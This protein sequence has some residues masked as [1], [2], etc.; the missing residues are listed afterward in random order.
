MRRL[1]TTILLG[2]IAFATLET[3]EEVQRCINFLTSSADY[4]HGKGNVLVVHGM[5]IYDVSTWQIAL[6]LA[7][8]DGFTSHNGEILSDLIE[9]QNYSLFSEEEDW[10]T[11]A[12]FF[13]GWEKI[14]DMVRLIGRGHEQS[15]S[16]WDLANDT[17][18]QVSWADW[19]PITVENAWV[20]LI[21]PLQSDCIRFRDLGYVPLDRLSMQNAAHVLKL[22]KALQSPIGGVYYTTTGS[23]GNIDPYEISVES[24]ASLYAGLTIFHQLLTL[25]PDDTEELKIEVEEIRN[26]IVHFFKNYAW[27]P[28][29]GV[30]LQG[31]YAYE[32][33]WQPIYFPKAVDVQTSTIM[34]IGP[35]T[36]DEWF[37]QGAAFHAWEKTKQWG[38]FFG[39]DHQLWGVGYSAQDGNGLGRDV[40]EGILSA[41]R[42]FGAL[43]LVRSLI[44]FYCQLPE[45][46]AWVVELLKEEM[47][48]EAGLKSLRT[49]SYGSEP[50]YE[51]SR[52]KEYD[53]LFSL[54]KDELAYLYASKSYFIP[55]GWYVNPLPSTSST[56]WAIMQ[57]Y[58]FNP[59][60]LN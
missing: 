43:N 57:Y 48:M 25:C 7:E 5:N 60:I 35:R 38:G 20:F 29:E 56:S 59:L 54:G 46:K 1:L 11:K 16:A 31:G 55:F 37:G 2:N 14:A 34:A 18:G 32:S 39:P 30:F 58:D 8:R 44:D 26:G 15:I 9:H 28:E 33:G 6:A 45:T 27:D 50:T 17:P 4:E 21:G 13:Y 40:S 23:L 51:E 36:I 52:P 53:T 22:F 47:G 12:P 10:A 3:R 49:D 42:T 24:N 19:Q 41:E